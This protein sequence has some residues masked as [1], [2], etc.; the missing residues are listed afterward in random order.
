[1]AILK[2][3]LLVYLQLDGF[4]LVQ[5]TQPRTGPLGSGGPWTAWTWPWNKFWREIH[6]LISSVKICQDHPSTLN[7]YVVALWFFPSKLG[8]G[9]SQCPQWQSQWYDHRRRKW[10]FGRLAVSLLIL[11]Q[12]AWTGGRP[13][14]SAPKWGLN[15]W[16][17]TNGFQRKIQGHTAWRFGTM[18]FDDFPFS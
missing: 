4:L 1:M 18:E 12:R 17:F 3:E 7:W 15:T 11:W 9:D 2:S 8:N 6:I 10:T 14:E 16:D 13:S 5:P